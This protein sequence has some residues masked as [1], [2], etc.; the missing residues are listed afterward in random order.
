MGLF[1]FK[2]NRGYE[3]RNPQNPD[4]IFVDVPLFVN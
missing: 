3:Y 1:C 2:D 4:K